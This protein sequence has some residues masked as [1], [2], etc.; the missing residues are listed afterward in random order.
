M[1]DCHRYSGQ[2]DESPTAAGKPQPIQIMQVRVMDVKVA[3]QIECVED[4]HDYYG[5]GA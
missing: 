2:E 4:Y 3:K 1:G 5:V